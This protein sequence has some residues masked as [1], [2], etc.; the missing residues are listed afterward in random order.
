MDDLTGQCAHLSLHTKECQTIPLTSA[1]ENNNRVLVAKLFTKRRVNIESLAR[2]LKSM[3]RFAQDFKVRDL[4]QNTILLLFT[5]EINVQ[6]IIPQGPWTFDKYLIGLYQTSAS[7]SVDDAKFDT[8]PFW[9]QLHNLP[10]S[11]MNKANALAI[12][13]TIG[14]VEQV[15]AS[16]FREC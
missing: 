11:C 10:L 15:D 8:N 14:S 16:P 1:I 6:K 3:W 5:H 13:N 12:K 7:E 2:T 9:I 4:T